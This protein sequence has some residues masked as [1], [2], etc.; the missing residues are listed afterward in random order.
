MP[1]EQ[2]S[3][4]LCTCCHTYRT[5]QHSTTTHCL[6]LSSSLPIPVPLVRLFSFDILLPPTLLLEHTV[7]IRYTL[8]PLPPAMAE[9]KQQAMDSRPGPSGSDEPVVDLSLIGRWDAKDGTNTADVMIYAKASHMILPLRL[10]PPCTCCLRLTAV[11]CGFP[12]HTL[13]EWGGKPRLR[14]SPPQRYP[15]CTSSHWSSSRHSCVLSHCCLTARAPGDLRE[16]RPSTSPRCLARS[17][18]NRIWGRCGA[19]RAGSWT[20]L[21]GLRATI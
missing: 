1:S 21:E 4:T 17:S 6:Y 18:G 2:T 3:L 7:T 20:A 19:G 10:P 9:Y 16:L 15:S 14:R 12:A 8:H 5:A 11:P 13:L